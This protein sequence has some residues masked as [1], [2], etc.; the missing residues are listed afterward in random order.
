MHIPVMMLLPS[1]QSYTWDRPSK[2]TAKLSH[3]GGTRKSVKLAHELARRSEEK[4]GKKA[5]RSGQSAIISSPFP[6]A[7]CPRAGV[8]FAPPR[9]TKSE[10]WKLQLPLECYF[11]FAGWQ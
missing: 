1:S 4:V 3:R 11:V 6:R 10:S 7:G 2:A 9:L 5:T 8:N